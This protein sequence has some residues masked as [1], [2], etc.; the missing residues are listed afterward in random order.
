MSF[1]ISEGAGGSPPPHLSGVELRAF[2]PSHSC[3]PLPHRHSW[4]TQKRTGTRG[5]R[6]FRPGDVVKCSCAC[7]TSRLEF[8]KVI[9]RNASAYGSHW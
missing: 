4:T 7:S 6:V 9:A 8:P 5:H 2:R 3:Q 1:S